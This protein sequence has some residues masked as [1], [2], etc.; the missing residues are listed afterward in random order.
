MRR[1][2][3]VCTGLQDNG[4]WCGPSSVRSGDIL[5]QD[6]YRIGGGDGFFTAVDPTDP[7][8]VFTE[9]QNGNVSR[10]DLRTG[11]SQSIRPR[12]RPQAGRGGGGGGRGGPPQPSNIVPE[13]PE[14]SQIRWNWSTPFMLSPHNPRIIYVGGNRLFRSYDRGDTWVMSPDLTRQVDRSTLSIMGLRGDLPGC[15]RNTRGQE[16]V[17]SRNDGVSN[18]GTIV[19]LSESSLA[20]GLLW[21]G[22]DDGAVQFSRDGGTTW[23]N[24]T[25]NLRVPEHYYV[26]RVE[27]SHFD[28]ATAY[29]ALD[30]H[31]SDDLKPYVYVTRDYGQSWTSI[32]SNLPASGNV[33]VIKQDPRN[34]N[35]LYAGTEF[36]FYVSLDE[37]ASWQRFM[38]NLPIV[39]IDDV[40]VHPRDNDLVLATH[41]RSVWIM[42]DV[43]PLQQLT[44]DVLAQDAHLFAPREA[45]LWKNDRR[46]AR[47]V[48]GHKNFEGENAPPGSALSY[49][50]KNPAGEASI[51]ITELATGRVFRNITGPGEAGL[52][53]VQWNLRGNPPPRQE[54]QQGGG[55][56][57]QQQGPI[58][59]PGVYRVTLSAGGREYSQNLVVVEDNWMMND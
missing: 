12:G 59:E 9:S 14:G 7:F 45:V 44:P 15:N 26:S 10:L 41:G 30:G 5:S 34:R 56:G 17:L 32:A 38:N 25:A 27:A 11:Q 42:D 54:G 20:P 16:C 46:L 6:W 33:N 40:I 48:T 21:I 55:G 39:R 49:Y 23:T 31:R 2:Y 19:T 22:T 43:S 36:A 1:P 50:L 51:V 4:S 35:L 37:G 58:A 24:V 52:N 53:R 18:Y 57:G 28:P 13:P 29:V 3:Y 47:S 8:V